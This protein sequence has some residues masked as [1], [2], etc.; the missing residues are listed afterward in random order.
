VGQVYSIRP[1]YYPSG[2]NFNN[3][4]TLQW[5][6]YIGSGSVGDSANATVGTVTFPITFSNTSNVISIGT[7]ATL[8]TSINSLSNTSF[9][10]QVKNIHNS[11]VNKGTFYWISTGF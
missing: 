5:G 2:T 10:I 4:I 1:I 9:K 3:L 6:K 7:S 11:S 8:N